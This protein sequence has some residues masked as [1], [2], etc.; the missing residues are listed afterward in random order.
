MAAV[1]SGRPAPR[2]DPTGVVVVSATRADD[3]TTGTAYV[4]AAIARVRRGR[5]APIA[6]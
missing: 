1:A 2:Y 6:G 3:V 4:P 5:N